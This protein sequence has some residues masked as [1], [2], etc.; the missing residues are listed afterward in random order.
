MIDQSN[1]HIT[2]LQTARFYKS[3]LDSTLSELDIGCAFQ[4]FVYEVL[5]PD[6]QDLHLFPCLGKDGAIDLS[7]TK[8]NTRTVVECKYIS[9]DRF[10][11][12]HSAWKSV[13]DKL[14][15]H[16]TSSNGPPKGQA[17]YGPWYRTNP[18]INE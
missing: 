15:K 18:T 9:S 14:N 17:Q 1:F 12:V 11:D 7:R 16:L 4:E 13:A 8:E 3:Q 2:N 10:I 6:Y 5:L